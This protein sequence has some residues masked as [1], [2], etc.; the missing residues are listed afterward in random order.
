ML[1]LPLERLG[2][3]GFFVVIGDTFRSL[4]GNDFPSG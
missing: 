2:A 3:P 4:L 1:P